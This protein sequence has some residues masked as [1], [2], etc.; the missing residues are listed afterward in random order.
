MR[1]GGGRF[2]L[3]VVVKTW[4]LWAMA[5]NF[6]PLHCQMCG[7]GSERPWLQLK[8]GHRPAR[9]AN[10]EC[11]SRRWDASKYPNAR[12]PEPTGPNTRTAPKERPIRTGIM[13][14]SRRPPQR[15]QI[16]GPHDAL[17]A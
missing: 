1:W 15:V 11:R 16:G 10:P 17:V 3:T 12:P 13:L 2:R 6:E 14:S 9:C 4:I 5:E 7:H 8:A